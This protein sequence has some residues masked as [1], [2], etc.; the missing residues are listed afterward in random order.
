MLSYTVCSTS[1]VSVCQ[2]YR[3]MPNIVKGRP[4]AT[5]AKQRYTKP[6]IP[7]LQSPRV[8]NCHCCRCQCGDCLA[9]VLCVRT[10]NVDSAISLKSWRWLRGGGAGQTGGKYKDANE[11]NEKITT[12]Y[13]G[14]YGQRRGRAGQGLWEQKRARRRCLSSPIITGSG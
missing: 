8:C 10:A 6:P 5:I 3:S 9:T 7:S 12:N 2:E 13:M 11:N 14:D 1:R 4:I